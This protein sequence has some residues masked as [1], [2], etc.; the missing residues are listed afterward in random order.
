MT[1]AEVVLG[2]EQHADAGGFA[3]HPALL[4]AALHAGL[5]PAD[6]TAEMGTEP[7]LPFVWSGVRLYATGATTVRVR[8]VPAGRDTLTVYV[9]DAE[10]EPVASVASL[11]LRPVPGGRLS[12]GGAG[13]ADSLY[14]LEWTQAALNTEAPA[15]AGTWAVVGDDA[16]F[17]ASL[18]TAVDG[19]V[20]VYP[21][22]ST[23]AAAVAE[24]APAPDVVLLAA[25][26][27]GSTPVSVPAGVRDVVCEVL[28][29]VQQWLADDAVSG[30][31]LV[32]VTSGGVAVRP[33]EDVPDLA[34]A[35]VWGLV[36]AALAEAPGRFALVDTDRD[37]AS[38][39]ALPGVLAS[40]A[41]PELA[42]REGTA[43]LPRLVRASVPEPALELAELNPSGTVLITGASGTLGGLMAR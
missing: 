34:A 3:I 35:G 28:A 40:G 36:R 43:Y 20:T 38:V 27:L 15:V 8:L 14:V 42:V 1:Y 7:L 23:L 31:R 26:A 18:V 11:A 6:D 2:E 17:A 22:V 5:V 21:D 4:D 10:G 9:A 41:E 12:A 24:G 30:A 32:V 39:R 25:P 29:E 13:G 37:D 33:G 19:A 16:P